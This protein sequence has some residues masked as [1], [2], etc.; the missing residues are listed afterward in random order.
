MKEYVVNKKIDYLTFTSHNPENVPFATKL[1]QMVK[2]VNPAYNQCEI[3][4][5]GMFHMWNEN[6]PQLGHHYIM[7]GKCLDW[8][9]EHMM[10]EIELINK[11]L[12]HGDIS[13]IDLAVTSMPADGSEHELQPHGIMELCKQGLLRSKL[14]PNNEVA[15]DGETQ[16]KYIG[17]PM[18]RRRLFRAYDKGIQM[19]LDDFKKREIR[20]ELETGKGGNVVGRMV[21]AGNDI[22]AI[23]RR[24]VDFP[25]S[26]VW[27]NIL[28]ADNSVLKHET[29]EV[30]L[31]AIE[32]MR[33]E[34][35][36]KWLWLNES[37]APM[38]KKLLNENISIDN[39]SNYENEQLAE[40]KK[41]SGML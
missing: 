23:I 30:K 35:L 26:E 34:R 8:I 29:G 20:Y 31:D 15:R 13:R 3:H 18:K 7:Q 4:Q 41:L 36:A 16:T 2:P 6:R 5:S 17:N 9:R 33:L 14:K 10:T 21:A 19:N 27:V 24:Y 22:G 39:I 32:A 40:F 38:I 28:G 12:N 25:S 37:I 11:V 1:Y